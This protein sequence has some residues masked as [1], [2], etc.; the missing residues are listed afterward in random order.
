MN[1]SIFEVVNHLGQIII[2]DYKDYINELSLI[3]VVDTNTSTWDDVMD[4]NWL[5]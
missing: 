1:Y 4:I 3:G 5:D 2:V